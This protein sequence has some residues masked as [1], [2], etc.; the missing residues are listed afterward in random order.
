MRTSLI[1]MLV[2]TACGLGEE[3]AAAEKAV[4]PAPDI[5]NQAALAFYCDAVFN[6]N[7]AVFME[8]APR[9]RQAA[10]MD[11]LTAQATEAKVG[12]WPDFQAKLN[13]LEP[14]ERQGWINRGVKAHGMEEACVAVRPRA[15]LSE[16]DQARLNEQRK[17]MMDAERQA[18]LD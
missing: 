16:A 7:P 11:T 12:T 18:H 9:E 6:L 3:Q 13:E 1:A 5:P 15:S 4:E 8:V 2:L 10:V 17:K 14:K